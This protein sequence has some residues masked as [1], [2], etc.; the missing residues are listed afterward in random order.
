MMIWNSRESPI[1]PPSARPRR[2]P[3]GY[4][5]ATVQPARPLAEDPGAARVGVRV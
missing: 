2:R 3:C 1:R 5:Y 4:L